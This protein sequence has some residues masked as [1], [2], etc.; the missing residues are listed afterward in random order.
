MMAAAVWSRDWWEQ[1][2]DKNP[3]LY[4]SE[5]WLVWEAINRLEGEGVRVVS[6]RMSRG[7]TVR[8]KTEAGERLIKVL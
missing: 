5:T 1:A 6:A 8:V 2:K 4:S 3:Y 7:Y